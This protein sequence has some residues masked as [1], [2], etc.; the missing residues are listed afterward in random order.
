MTPGVQNSEFRLEL[1]TALDIEAA[2]DAGFTTAIVP[3]G[4]IEQHGPHLPLRMDADH[5]DALAVRLA[6][7]LGRAL[8]AP[9][10]AVGC[11]NHHLSFAGTI[12]L[13]ATTFEAIC[14]DYCTSLAHHGFQTIFFF[15]AH[16]G[17]F[18]VMEKMLPA[19]NSAVSGQAEV[20]AFCNSAGW[21]EE[22][23]RAVETAGGDAGNVGGHADI[24]ETSLMMR[25]RPESVRSDRFEPGRRGTL[26]E[27]ERVAMRAAGI[28]SISKNGILGDPAGSTPEIGDTCL[29]AIADLLAR[30]FRGQ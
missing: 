22:W 30:F 11:S 23:R 2:L 8:I 25:L 21:V 16:L 19:L 3:C 10:I 4:A 14:R 20:K 18:G 28:R 6:R 27:D 9:T 29:A 13:Q 1:M 5:A 24:A 12:S 26:T 17:N 7:I 15:S